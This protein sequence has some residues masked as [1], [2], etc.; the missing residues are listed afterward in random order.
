[1]PC[2]DALKTAI[3]TFTVDAPNDEPNG[4]RERQLEVLGQALERG[5][6]RVA[7]KAYSRMCEA[8]AD[9][10]RALRI[11]AEGHFGGDFRS[12]AREPS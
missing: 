8:G 3:R 5:D 10:L 11:A 4:E 7:R 2:A 9:D 12:P 6:I 1:M